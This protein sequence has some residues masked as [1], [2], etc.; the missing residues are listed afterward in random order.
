[1]ERAA[2]VIDQCTRIAAPARVV[3]QVIVDLDRYPEWN[4]FVV[5]C[6]STLQVGAPIDMRVRLLP[7]AMMQ[8]ETIFEHVA[9]ERLCYGLRGGFAGSVESQRCH[10]VRAAG[11]GTA[12]YESRFALGGR[13]APV[14]RALLGSRLERGFSSMT[15]ALV[16]RA[17]SLA[18]GGDR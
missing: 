3:W 6:R 15:E 18:R 5:A 2:I 4:P 14:V 17:E 10:V 7:V 1:V 12:E 13:L 8:R 11:D 9:G 16:H